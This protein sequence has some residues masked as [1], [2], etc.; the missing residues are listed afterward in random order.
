[1]PRGGFQSVIITAHVHDTLSTRRACGTQMSSSSLHRKIPQ[2]AHPADGEV[3]AQTG[4]ATAQRGTALWE[5]RGL[6]L[7][8]R[9]KLSPLLRDT[10]LASHRPAGSPS[11]QSPLPSGH[12]DQGSAQRDAH[13]PSPSRTGLWAAQDSGLL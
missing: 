5:P 7:P 6:P 4:Q 9:R 13:S 10:V 12:T 3:T 1:M 11:S 8:A 2:G